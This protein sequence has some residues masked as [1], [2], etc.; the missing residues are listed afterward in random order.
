MSQ[1]GQATEAPCDVRR[2]IESRSPARRSPGLV[3]RL[4]IL[5]SFL[6]SLQ[7]SAADKVFFGNLH[8]HTSYSDGSG[9]PAQA[10]AGARSA[11]LDFM[12]VTE[13]NHR[14]AEQGNGGPDDGRL[15]G[16]DHALYQGPGT[17]SLIS[18][19]KAAT[20]DG[21]FVALYGQEFSTISSGN[22]MNVFEVGEV[23]ADDTV[24]NGA[25]DELVTWLA[26]HPDSTG[27]PAIVQFNHPE[28][29]DEGG[30]QYGADDFGTKEEWI[31]T[32]GQHAFLMEMVNGPGTKSGKNLK[33]NS[34][35]EASYR[36]FLNLG[37]RVA[38]TGNQDNHFK[39]WG[40]STRT[41]TGIIADELSKE[42]LLA[43]IRARH[44][45]ATEDENLQV[46]FRVQGQLCG[47]VLSPPAV[48]QELDI[49]YWIHDSDEPDAGYE[50]VVYSDVVGGEDV[51]EIIEE[52]SAEE[53]SAD[54]KRIE[55]IRYTG[56]AQYLFFKLTQFNEH[57]T[58]N[59]R[60][61]T[62]PRGS[63]RVAEE[64]LDRCPI[65]RA[66]RALWR[67]RILMSTTCPRN[68][69][70]RSV[71]R[72]PTASR[73]RR[74]P[75][76][77]R[78]TRT[79]RGNDDRPR[80]NEEGFLCPLKRSSARRAIGFGRIACVAGVLVCIASNAHALCAS[81]RWELLWFAC[82]VGHE[83]SFALQRDGTP[84]CG[85]GNC[86]GAPG[87]CWRSQGSGVSWSISDGAISLSQPNDY[88]VYGSTWLYL[89]EAT[90][91]SVPY[92]ADVGRVW[93]NGSVVPGAPLSLNLQ[94]G[95]NHLEFT[96]YNQ[97]QGSSITLNFPFA[98]VADLMACAQ[99]AACEDDLD[100]DGDGLLD[101]GSD[102]GCA[103]AGD[104]SE[105]GAS[106]VCDDGLDNDGDGLP[107][108]PDDPGC[109]LAYGSREHP[110][111]DDGLDNDG[112]GG[113]D[114]D[115]VPGPGGVPLDPQCI[116][117]PAANQE[118]V[119][120][121]GAAQA[122]IP[123]LALATGWRWRRR[124]LRRKEKQPEF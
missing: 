118:R 90:N 68:A 92:A 113:I 65:P 6:M 56:G 104:D 42:K 66:Q 121:T 12:A 2:W 53:A 48:G 80:R 25:F 62:A 106:Y 81:G 29:Y 105:R 40:T 36:A 16:K 97:N 64:V 4:A 87:T 76:G 17:Q 115:G 3:R 124:S 46:V 67:Q 5:T 55:D 74:Q 86:P 22:H 85:S 123:V 107:D 89:L 112:D 116:V 30:K 51:A 49:Q 34:P 21:E 114:W 83:N 84:V 58:R 23:I 82:D 63:C 1:V 38:P 95:W 24:H 35:A 31:E 27:Q 94:A 78:S 18:A 11:G 33:P 75:R 108:Y 72:R 19:A 79:V 13:H 39:N 110:Q 70:M 99:I 28:K 20:Q 91:V 44:V 102:P 8:S 93:L 15:I 69:A 57:Q 120:G 52:I 26:S 96:S 109:S 77:A 41:R 32:I 50:V 59:D 117:N 54:W 100:N 111:C 45:Y 88:Q 7:A 71:S 119:C 14:K 98:Q 73:A 47:D 61:W 60:V 9:T 10:F 122:L 43:A 101:L 37:F 103:S